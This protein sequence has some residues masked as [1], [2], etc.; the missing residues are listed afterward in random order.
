MYAPTE[1]SSS[2]VQEDLDISLNEN[3]DQAKKHE[4]HL[5]LGILMQELACKAKRISLW[6][7]IGT[8]QYDT[9]NKNGERLVNLC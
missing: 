7:L 9:T 5:F 8:V 4:I 3:L 2:S 1:R 6:L